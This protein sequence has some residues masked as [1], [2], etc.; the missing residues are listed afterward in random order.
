MYCTRSFH[1]D[2]VVSG[3][4]HGMR[5]YWSTYE[6]LGSLPKPDQ[7]ICDAEVLGT[8]IIGLTTRS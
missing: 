7:E 1:V 5:G 2:S 6:L 4:E 8:K 3:A